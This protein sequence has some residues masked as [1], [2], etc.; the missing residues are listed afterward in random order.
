MGKKKRLNGLPGNL[1]HRYFSSVFYWK[2]GYMS[3]WIW[4]TA[5]E[6]SITSIE[7]DIINKSVFPKELEIEAIIGH[8]PD[9]CETIHI[10]LKS[11]NFDKDFIIE[12]KLYIEIPENENSKFIK[13]KAILKDINGEIYEGK[14]L[15]ENVYSKPFKN[16][17]K[18]TNNKKIII[19]ENKWWKF[20]A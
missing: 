13:G 19:I 12:A 8:L 17:P 1:I 16:Y 18:I 2:N 6:K 14:Q 7:I 5:K 9:L 11:N 15:T 10:N 20:W 3:D 4:F